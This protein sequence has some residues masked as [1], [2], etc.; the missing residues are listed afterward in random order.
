MPSVRVADVDYN[1]AALIKDITAAV[2]V[3]SEIVVTPEL[4]I[5]GYSCGDLFMQQRLLTEAEKAVGKIIE[6]SKAWKALVAVGVPVRNHGSLYNCAAIIY[7][8]RLL[9]LVPKR[10]LPE[11]G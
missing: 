1:S 11:Y 2:E 5:T 4:G 10:Y 8:G 3:G 7:E 6:A 9:G